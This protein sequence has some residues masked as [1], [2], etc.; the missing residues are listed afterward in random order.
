MNVG[1]TVFYK[2]DPGFDIFKPFND[3]TYHYKNI[4]L[5]KEEIPYII[6]E[7]GI[8]QPSH[9]K[10]GNNDMNRKYC[11]VNH[12]T[13]GFPCEIFKPYDKEYIKNKYNLR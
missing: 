4:R 7:I 8:I 13:M 12:D 10:D 5:L 11:C 9:F 2:G 3:A 1:D 6:T